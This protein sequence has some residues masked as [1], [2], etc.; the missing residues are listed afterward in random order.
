MKVAEDGD[1][2][3]HIHMLNEQVV[4]LFESVCVLN[5]GYFMGNHE[6]FLKNTV[7]TKSKSKD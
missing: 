5:R 4:A 7:V 6:V 1:A 2:S 3:E